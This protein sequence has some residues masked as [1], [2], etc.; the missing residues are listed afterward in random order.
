MVTIAG[1]AVVDIAEAVEVLAGLVAEAIPVVAARIPPDLAAE[2]GRL[3]AAR[4]EQ[5]QLAGGRFAGDVADPA[6]SGVLAALGG[7]GPAVPERLLGALELIVPDL[8]LAGVVDLSPLLSQPPVQRFFL[9]DTGGQSQAIL[10]VRFLEP[11]RPGAAELAAALAARL[12]GH[13]LIAPLLAVGAEVTGE[14]PVA[15]AHGAAYFALAVAAASAVLGVWRHPPLVDSPAA[16][17]VGVAA[18]TVVLLLRDAPVPAGYA[19]ALQARIRQEYRP[20]RQPSYCFNVVVARGPVRQHREPRAFAGTADQFAQAMLDEVMSGDPRLASRF[21]VVNVWDSDREGLFVAHHRAGR[22][23][24]DPKTATRKFT[25]VTGGNLPATPAALVLRTDFSDDAAWDAV[26]TAS[27]AETP[28]GFVAG[29]SFVSY[30]AFAGMTVEHAAA[31]TSE[32]YRTF[33][34]V[35]DHVTVTDPEMPLVAVDLHDEPGRRF[36]ALPGTIASIGNS[37]S[38]GTMSFGEFADHADPDGVF[39]RSAPRS[40]DVPTADSRLLTSYDHV[41]ALDHGQFWLYSCLCPEEDYPLDDLPELAWDDLPDLGHRANE[42]DG[43][44]QIPVEYSFS[45]TLVVLSPHQNN[46]QMPLRAEIWDGPPP[47]DLADWPEAF[48]AHLDVDPHGLYY[49]S[50]TMSSTRLGVPPGGYHALITGRGFVA[51]GWPRS[52]IPGDTWRIRL[53]PSA[54]PQQARRLTAWR[55]PAH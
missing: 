7:L 48:E 13:P 27:I 5:V 11:L 37:L 8:A 18:G 30:P 1:C 46:F 34:F 31:L 40:P 23:S 20:P 16:A 25:P 47:D 21:V 2:L 55:P 32:S 49:S 35:A 15:A 19:A 51:H 29:L 54:G 50:T 26:C 45:G 12:A 53:W 14:E 9:P 52:T 22:A 6:A 4:D 17:V 33:L 43:I 42:G 24:H 10:A 44:A 41:V 38:L 36:R 28:E 39:R 3:G